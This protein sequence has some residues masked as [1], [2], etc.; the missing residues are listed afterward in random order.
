MNTLIC[1]Y[2][3]FVAVAE[4]FTFSHNSYILE[5]KH[6]E[7]KVQKVWQTSKTNCPKTTET[8]FV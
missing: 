4:Y 3:E 8:L 2:P 7:T 5:T 6:K 1:N